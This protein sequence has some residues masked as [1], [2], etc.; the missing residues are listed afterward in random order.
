MF[1]PLRRELGGSIHI[2]AIGDVAVTVV[3]DL[4]AELIAVGARPDR[5]RVEHASVVTP[6]LIERMAELEIV[7]SVQPAFVPSDARWLDRRLGT[8][9]SRWAYPFRSMLEAGVRLVGGSDAPVEQPDPLAGVRAAV[10]RSG[11]NLEESLEPW[12]ALSLFA[13]G[14]FE[15]GATWVSPDLDRF[16]R[17]V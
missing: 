9:R 10:D 8:D 14:T 3:L 6:A 17:L 2:H 15:G 5:L 7:A 12:E 1:G 16:E 13:D 11:W 4:F